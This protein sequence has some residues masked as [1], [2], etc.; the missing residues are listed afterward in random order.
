[1]SMKFSLKMQHGYDYG[2]KQPWLTVPGHC[3]QEL[4][5]TGGGEALELP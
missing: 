1:M 5:S 2:P 4:L 3:G